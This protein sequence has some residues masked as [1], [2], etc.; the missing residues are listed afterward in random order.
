M[1]DTKYPIE[2]TPNRPDMEE[3]MG[4]SGDID[5]GFADLLERLKS[6]K[7][8]NRNL[9]V[10]IAAAIGCT[11]APQSNPYNSLR[12]LHPNGRTMDLP[13]YTA[14]IDAALTLVPK[15]W[16]WGVDCRGIVHLDPAGI[17]PIVMDGSPC[18]AELQAAT[19]AL[20]ICIA[21]L[22]ALEEK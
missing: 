6:A 8:G 20:A 13:A 4:A 1:D 11:K 5:D 10:E 15:G 7:E 17:F 19:P 16:Y 12:L 22:Y 14:S 21:A 18:F 3:T 2:K 9:D